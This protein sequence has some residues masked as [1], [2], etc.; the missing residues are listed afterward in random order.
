LAALKELFGNPVIRIEDSR[1]AREVMTVAT[2]AVLRGN[3]GEMKNPY[4]IY[5]S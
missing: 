4:N 1:G 3:V 5:L 2:N